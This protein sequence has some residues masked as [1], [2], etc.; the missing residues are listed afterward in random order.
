MNKD[1]EEL[2]NTNK[3]QLLT[4]TYRTLRPTTAEHTFFP[5]IH[6]TYTKIDYILGHKINLN[7]VKRT[8]IQ[9]NMS[10]DQNRIK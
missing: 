6:E 7:R 9:R 5:S 1:T 4:D 3:K 2:N 8:E 10:S